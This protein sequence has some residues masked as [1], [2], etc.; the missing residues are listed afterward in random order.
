MK[1]LK[2]VILEQTVAHWTLLYIQNSNSTYRSRLIKPYNIHNQGFFQN[3]TVKN[4][5]ISN[6]ISGEHGLMLAIMVA[7][8][9]FWFWR[10]R[11]EL[12]QNDQL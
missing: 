12:P 8:I 1:M 3:I 11:D 2:K 5:E 7:L 4:S 10:K 6:Y 9:G